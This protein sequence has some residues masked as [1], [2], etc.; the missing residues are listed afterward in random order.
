MADTDRLIADMLKRGTATAAALQVFRDQLL[1][2]PEVKALSHE[3][4]FKYYT[5][6]LQTMMEA[7]Q[8][9]LR[10]HEYAAILAMLKGKND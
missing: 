3:D 10:P 1:E 9:K 7:A 8:L 6:L 2:H 4:R 5:L